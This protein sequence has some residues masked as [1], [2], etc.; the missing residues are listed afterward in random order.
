M[1]SSTLGLGLATLFIHCLF[2]NYQAMA[3]QFAC[4]KKGYSGLILWWEMRIRHIPRTLVLSD[5]GKLEGNI[6]IIETLYMGL[7]WEENL[8]FIY[9]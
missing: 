4:L 3:G 8:L 9:F 6:L 7:S 5:L 2:G 1:E